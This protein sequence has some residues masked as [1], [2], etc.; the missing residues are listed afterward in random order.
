[1]R[2]VR[3]MMDNSLFQFHKGTI[4]TQSFAPEDSPVKVF[5]FHKGTIKTEATCTIDV[6]LR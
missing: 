6:G 5:Q 1:M 4:K 3:V 2:G